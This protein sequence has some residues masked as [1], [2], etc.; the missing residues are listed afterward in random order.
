MHIGQAW[1]DP[2]TFPHVVI[3]VRHSIEAES[4]IFPPNLTPTNAISY[5]YSDVV[6]S[7]ALA[8]SLKSSAVSARMRTRA[9]LPYPRNPVLVSKAFVL[10]FLHLERITS[11]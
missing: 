1:E 3:M 2:D 4:H 7:H 9:P 8:Y 10:S 11:L 5:L 6:Q